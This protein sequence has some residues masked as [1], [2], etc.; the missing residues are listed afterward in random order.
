MEE[1]KEN[2]DSIKKRSVAEIQAEEEMRSTLEM[3][4]KR[5]LEEVVNAE[6]EKL[7]AMMEKLESE[8]ESEVH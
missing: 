4:A 6:D 8:Y 5:D 3:R 1:T 2:I 7:K